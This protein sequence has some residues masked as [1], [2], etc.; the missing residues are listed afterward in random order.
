MPRQL[1]RINIFKF[2]FSSIKWLL[3]VQTTVQNTN[4]L[5]FNVINEKEKRQILTFKMAEPA[6]S[7]MLCKKSIKES[8]N[9]SLQTPQTHV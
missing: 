7:Q 9:P 6:N 8:G 4:N 5:H 2:I 1:H 3:F